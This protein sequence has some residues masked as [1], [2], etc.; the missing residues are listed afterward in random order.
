MCSLAQ[1]KSFI[2]I[3]PL[4]S[5]LPPPDPLSASLGSAGEAEL[6]SARSTGREGRKVKDH[7]PDRHG[8]S[9]LTK[10]SASASALP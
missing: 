6:I 8:C 7:G 10:V 4:S 2:A 5:V 3:Y 9:M 1:L